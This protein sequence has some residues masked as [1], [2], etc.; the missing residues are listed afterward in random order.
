M[1]K[2]AFLGSGELA[3][4]LSNMAKD[5][6]L[7]EIAGFIDGNREMGSVVNGYPVLGN[8]DD[9]VGL[10]KKGV[11]DCIFIGV[12]YL[13]F[14]VREKLY[15]RFKGVVPF[16]NII[17]PSAYIHPTASIGEGILMCDEV[18]ICNNAVIEDNVLITLRSVVNH[19]NHIKKHS[20][21]STRVTTA[22]HTIIGERC[23]LGVGV[24]VSDGV[25]ICDDVWLSPGS[26]VV[27][28]IS[29]PGH[30]LSQVTKLF[31][32]D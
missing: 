27:K 2:I 12:G 7:Y 10:F 30:Y 28:D 11:F 20:F 16:A 1:K 4:D 26:V 9:V 15:E 5:W 25:T 19:F 14:K 8:D 29:L 22:G 24:T 21:F 31:K 13:N 32:I 6:N 18:Y 3:V 17:S 23:F